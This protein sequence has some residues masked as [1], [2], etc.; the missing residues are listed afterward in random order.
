M[1]MLVVVYPWYWPGADIMAR[2]QRTRV[3]MAAR[4][5]IPRPYHYKQPFINW[6]L[7]LTLTLCFNQAI[8]GLARLL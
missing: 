2:S 6:L 1:Y 4:R 5:S 8:M 7:D 3:I